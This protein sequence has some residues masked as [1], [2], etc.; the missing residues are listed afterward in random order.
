MHAYID[1]VGSIPQRMTVSTKGHVHQ[2]CARAKQ[3]KMVGEL[4]QFSLK[5]AVLTIITIIIINYMHAGAINYRYYNY[6]LNATNFI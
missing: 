5:T 4:E 3:E 1:D 6:R 2:A